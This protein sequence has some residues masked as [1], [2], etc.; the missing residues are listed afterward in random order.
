M[1]VFKGIKRKQNKA[2]SADLTFLGCAWWIEEG[3]HHASKYVKV[4]IMRQSTSHILMY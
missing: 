3:I 1:K 4:Y 2:E